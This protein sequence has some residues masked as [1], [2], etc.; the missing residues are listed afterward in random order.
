MERDWKAKSPLPAAP[1][2]GRNPPEHPPGPSSH[3]SD[4]RVA[5]LVPFGILQGWKGGPGIPAG[6]LSSTWALL[7]AMTR[8]WSLSR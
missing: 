7:L 5:G 1:H 6:A 2:G 8:P 3:R 4:V